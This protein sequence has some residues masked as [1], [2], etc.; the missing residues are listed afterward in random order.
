M[1]SEVVGDVSVVV[2][3]SVMVVIEVSDDGDGHE[4]SGKS[5]C[6]FTFAGAPQPARES[7]ACL[8][9]ASGLVDYCSIKR[10]ARLFNGRGLRQK[11]V[12]YMQPQLIQ[13]QGQHSQDSVVPDCCYAVSS[14]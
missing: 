9:P 6:R 14:R 5:S 8:F 3:S 13:V 10:R 12:T 11:T 7:P 4:R 1:E 2:G